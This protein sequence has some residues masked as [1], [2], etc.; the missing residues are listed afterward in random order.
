MRIF[1]IRLSFILLF[2]WL[3]VGSTLVMKAQTDAEKHF[4]DSTYVRYFIR[5]FDSLYLAPERFIDTS[6]VDLGSL[7]LLR[8]NGSL[9]QSLSNTSTAHQSLIWQPF[10]RNGFDVYQP[11][12][13]NFLRNSNNIH[14]LMPLQPFTELNYM[15]GS[16]KE[17]HLKARFAREIR[18]RLFIGMHYSLVNS[19]GIYKNNKINNNHI[20]FTGRYTTNNQRYR[21]LAHY[22]YNKMEMGENGG[23]QD[24]A[25]FEE[26]KETDRRLLPVH[27]IDAENMIKQSGFGLEQEYVV[28]FPRKVWINDSVEEVRAIGLGRISHQL[29]YQRNQFI[30]TERSPLEPFYAPYD[31]VLDSTQTFD[32]LYVSVLRNRLQWNN[33]GVEPATQQPPFYLYAGI[34]SVNSQAPDGLGGRSDWQLNP[35]GGI[36]ISLFRSFFIDG[37]VKLITGSVATGD[38]QLKGGVRQ[39]L[40]TESRNLGDLFFRVS[41]I[42]QSASWFFLYFDSNHIRWENDFLS[43]RIL[44]AHGGYHFKGFTLGGHWHLL[45]KYLYIDKF[46]RPAQ[47][48]G[49]FSLFNLY[50]NLQLKLGKFDMTGSVHLQKTDNDTLLHIPDITAHLKITY[51]SDIFGKAATIQPGMELKWFSSYL[52]D[53]WMP[54]TRSFYLQFEKEIG[55][56]PY[57]D[58]H[59]ALKVK[60]AR[61]YIQLVNLLGFMESY[62]YYTTPHHPMPDPKFYFGVSWRFYK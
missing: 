40:G 41:L 61:L 12:Y 16:K 24:D 32:S 55:D 60:R 44:S 1:D 38:L 56:F 8:Q 4:I 50:S 10:F 54:A 2:I 37:T 3:G 59:L 43:E 25:D 15:M 48:S 42:N 45:D 19:P 34:E 27:L 33:L 62:T 17:Q 5:S 7:D 14:Y 28:A 52:A 51:T 57:L 47:T 49:T 21:L 36:Q 46:A 20:Y 31:Q 22:F 9:L 39:Y 13:R 6:L 58:V 18:P 53:A 35:Y 23:I 30:Y 29:E 11:A 26:N